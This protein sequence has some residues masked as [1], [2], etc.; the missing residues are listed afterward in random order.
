MEPS[1]AAVESH[2]VDLAGVPLATLRSIDGRALAASLE[3]LRQGIDHP[4]ASVSDFGT[5]ERT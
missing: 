1:L 5:P 4:L 2:L 3:Q